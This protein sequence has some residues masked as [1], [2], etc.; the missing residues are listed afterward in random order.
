MSHHILVDIP[1]PAW[2][3]KKAAV[4]HSGH[5]RAARAPPSPARAPTNIPSPF[6]EIKHT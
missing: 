5:H 3:I 4:R 6:Q 2:Q 1:H